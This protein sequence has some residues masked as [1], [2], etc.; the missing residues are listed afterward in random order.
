MQKSKPLIQRL[1]RPLHSYSEQ[2]WIEWIMSVGYHVSRLYE[3]IEA[4]FFPASFSH[5][6]NCAYKNICNIASET[7]KQFAIETKWNRGE[8]A[9]LFIE[10]A[11]E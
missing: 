11:G 8:A 4:G 5:C 2:N 7:D 9:D 6:Y 1:T 3:H 10:E